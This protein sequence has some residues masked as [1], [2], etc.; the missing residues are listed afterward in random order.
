VPSGLCNVNCLQGSSCCILKRCPSHLN[1]PILITL[2]VRFTAE[3]VKLII[4]SHNNNNNNNN[5]LILIIP[6]CRN[7]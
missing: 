2:P 5:N 7:M 6:R 3:L 1:L 4:V